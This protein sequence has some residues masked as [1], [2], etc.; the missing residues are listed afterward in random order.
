MTFDCINAWLQRA[1]SIGVV[2][3]LVLVAACNPAPK[4]T[5]VANVTAIT[6]VTVIDAINGVRTGRTVVFD[7]DA[8][9][10]VQPADA[11]LTADKT[12]DGTGKYLIP[13]LW[14]FHVHLTYNDRVTPTMPAQFLSYGITSVRDT[15]GLMPKMLPI[16]RAM[17]ANGAVAPRV[18]FAGPLLDGRFVVYDGDSQPEIGLQNTTPEQARQT[19]RALKAQGVDFIKIYEMVSPDVFAAMVETANEL[20]LP[21]ASHLPLSMRANTAGVAVDSMEHMRNIEMD[22]ASSGPALHKERLERLAN[23][24]GLSGFDLRSSLHNL[25]RLPAIADYDQERCDQVIAALLSTIQ[26][27]TLQL[28]STDLVQPWARADWD[29]ALDRLPDSAA[30]RWRVM[31]RQRRADRRENVDTAFAKW[32]LF[33]TGRAHAAGVPIGAGTDTPIGWSLPGYSLHM[34]LDLLVRAGLEPLEALAAATVRPAEFFSLQDRMG[35][36]DAGKVADLLLL[37]ANPLDDIANAKRIS[38][39]ISKGVV[40]DV[41]ELIE[42]ARSSP[43]AISRILQYLQSWAPAAGPTDRPAS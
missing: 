21:I 32:G 15:G 18:F 5:A 8:I 40:H 36:V 1:V 2:A 37:D 19:I 39:V 11:P 3:G 28:Y 34:E 42:A 38:L 14:D 12:I 23:R 24:D 43:S 4:D 13:G 31:T 17:R 7:G 20:D 9:T 35:T 27:P 22:C 30:E 41:A 33:L 26:V 16:V 25:Q 10:A 29:D 6:N